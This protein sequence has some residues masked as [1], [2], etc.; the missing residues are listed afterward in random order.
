MYNEVGESKMYMESSLITNNG[1][2]PIHNSCIISHSDCIGNSY[3]HSRLVIAVLLATV[4]VLA[5][6]VYSQN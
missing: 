2:I 3:I 5:T 6:A 1:A 4:T